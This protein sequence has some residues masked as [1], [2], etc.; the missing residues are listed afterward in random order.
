MFSLIVR[1]L[2]TS[3]IPNSK[4]AP[5]INLLFQDDAPSEIFY[6]M[7]F[8]RLVTD[9]DNKHYYSY[10]YLFTLA[11]KG[12]ICIECGRH[13]TEQTQVCQ[14]CYNLYYDIGVSCIVS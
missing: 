13:M 12:N 5:I 7:L 11:C 2:I 14:S 3:Y 6:K 10:R 1:E 8:H 9:Y 4:I